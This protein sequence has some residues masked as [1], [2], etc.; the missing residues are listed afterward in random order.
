MSLTMLGGLATAQSAISIVGTQTGDTGVG[1]NTAGRAPGWTFGGFDPGAGNKLVALV[2]GEFVGGGSGLATIDIT[3]GGIAMTAANS[4]V[5]SVG[6]QHAFIY[7]MDST[8]AGVQD[9]NVTLSSAGGLSG[10]NGM[11][12]SLFSISG[13]SAG[14]PSSSDTDNGGS[15]INLDG[16]AG[17]I[18][19]ISQ[20]T[21]Q[22]SSA[23]VPPAGFTNTLFDSLSGADDGIG[24]AQHAHSNQLIAADGV[25]N[26]VYTGGGT[27]PAAAGVVFSASV[28]PEPS[29]ALLG[30]LGAFGLLLRRR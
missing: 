6:G 2:T 25:I 19:F 16:V 15:T 7:Y 9:F 27:R 28:V 13:A 11:A 14:G 23:T 26:A 3:F 30:A 17:G 24:S 22:S 8:T 5:S 21:N 12:Y 10:G 29:V 4:V 18:A 1:S 20:V